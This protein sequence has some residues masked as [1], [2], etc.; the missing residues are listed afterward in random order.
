MKYLQ[1]KCQII[2]VLTACALLAGTAVAQ[3]WPQ[4][5]GPERTGAVS[6]GTHLLETVPDAGF[7]ELWW[8]D[9]IIDKNLVG[10]GSDVGYS[11]P[12]AAD[13]RVFLYLNQKV[14]DDSPFRLSWGILNRLGCIDTPLPK[15]LALKVEAARNSPQRLAL[16]GDDVPTWASDWVADNLTHAQYVVFAVQIENRL[17]RGADAIE[18]G[19]LGKL[20]AL[21]DKPYTSRDDFEKALRGTGLTQ[22]WID[23]TVKELTANRKRALD[24]ICCFDAK[25]GKTIWKKEYPGALFEYG[26]SST[27]CIKG[28]FLYVC[29]GKT[30]YCLD[31]VNGAEVWQAPCPAKEVS[32]SPIVAD[33]I[34]LIQAGSLCALDA[35]SGK[36]LWTRPEFKGIHASPTIWRKDGK[37]YAVQ[38]SGLVDLQTGK[39]LW[40]MDG[41]AN[42]PSPVVD[43]DL[44][45]SCNGY[46]VIHCYHL[47]LDKGEVLWTLPGYGTG[48][49][50]PII[51]QHYL[52]GT[53]AQ[54]GP[55]FCVDMAT[56]QVKWSSPE[57]GYGT[58]SFNTTSCIIADGKIFIDGGGWWANKPDLIIVRA[59]PEKFDIVGKG[60]LVNGSFRSSTPT[61][62]DGLLFIRGSSALVCYDLRVK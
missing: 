60:R 20:A 16:T 45:V 34:L 14:K 56:G 26:T 25:T 33:G 48:S 62:A 57:R 41:N 55:L 12:I 39:L 37:T 54:N 42:D 31:V 35:S 44:L 9:P 22:P 10:Q 59:T 28:E 7:A 4:W 24:V 29:G 18:L 5:R 1:Y 17:I 27:P 21:Q 58:Y 2:V 47:A 19:T 15:E 11:S 38:S 49:A 36:L 51:F 40:I 52:Y 46:G 32:S 50:T 30:I 61:I 43:G 8:S 3:D 6:G 13:G 23:A 53:K